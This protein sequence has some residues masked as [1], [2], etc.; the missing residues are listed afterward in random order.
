MLYRLVE[1]EKKERDEMRTSRNRL[2]FM[3]LSAMMAA[4]L[5]VL[6][7]ITIPM[8]ALPMTLS[9]F[10]LF[11]VAS[12]FPVSVTLC[13]T[14]VYLAVGAVGLPV[15]S[16]FTGGVFAFVSPSGGFLWGYLPAVLT[17][18]FFCS[19]S[20][21]KLLWTLMGML[22]GLFVLYAFGLF[23]FVLLTGASLGEAFLAAVLPFLL[24]DFAKIIAVLIL[25]RLFRKRIL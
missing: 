23:G 25:C 12:L 24:P 11:L 19:K 2:R 8:G 1:M 20:G 10:A 16:S 14:A 18:S 4:V 13:T 21:G 9:V 7:P 6:S 5:C 22:L 3:G 17:V 15:F